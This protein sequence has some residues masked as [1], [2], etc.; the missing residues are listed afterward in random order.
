MV[1]SIA[2]P[3]GI[4]LTSDVRRLDA[5]PRQLGH[6][7]AR[8]ELVRIHR[9]AYVR[10]D[11]WRALD[12]AQRYR[13]R[14]IAAARASRSRPILSHQSAAAFWGVPTTGDTTHLVHVL[15]TPMA[16]TRTENGF[17]RHAAEIAND[18][19]VEHDGVR[20]TSFRRTLIDLA[21]DTPFASA[22]VSLDWS[23]RPL[24]KDLPPR[25]RIDELQEYFDAQPGERF[26]RRVHR[27]LEFA[28]PRSES[29]GE[30]L[31]RATLHELGFPAPVLQLEVRDG[32]GLIGTCD[33][34]WPE[35]GLLGEFDGR[36]KYTRD[37]VRPGENVEEIVVREKIREDR[38]RATGRGM[39]R[40]LWSEALQPALLRD[41]L[42]AAGLP[43]RR[44]G[45]VRITPGRIGGPEAPFR[46]GIQ[47]PGQ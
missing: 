6:A 33:F 12:A 23:L 14:V 19:V 30:S 5:D 4:F 24:R 21:R 26:R 9:G 13:R 3:N 44:S 7:V 46:P 16:G 22:V 20:V 45:P 11:E 1:E 40:W 17:R 10:S 34:A 39:A 38:M 37:M 35:F 27:A 31:S 41:K 28:S 42:V 43:I 2:S 18:D 25:V 8:G 32:R 29:P 47:K 36:A 15:T